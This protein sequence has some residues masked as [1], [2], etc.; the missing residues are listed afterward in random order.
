M[1][2]DHA[3]DGGEARKPASPRLA[4]PFAP[5]VNLLNRMTLKVFNALYFGRAPKT[6]ATTI[7][8]WASYF[9]PLDAIRLEPALRSARPVSASKRLSR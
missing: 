7:A 8:P 9:H 5:P 6:P 3:E 2:G 4:V 1:A